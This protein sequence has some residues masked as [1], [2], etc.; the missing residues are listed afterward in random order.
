MRAILSI[1][2]LILLFF[3]SATTLLY[4]TFN[5]NID[6]YFSPKDPIYILDREIRSYFPED[7]V[8]IVLLENPNLFSDDFLGRLHKTVKKLQKVQDMNRVLTLT[9]V[10]HIQGTQD[11]F[12]ISPLFDP[13]E[14]FK[15]NIEERK[16]KI[17]QD[18][19][20]TGS[21][22][23]KDGNA[24]AVVLRPEKDSTT[25]AK[26]KLRHRSLQIFK[27]EQLGSSITA[28]SGTS[29][30]TYMQFESMLDSCKKFIPLSV[31]ISMGLICW[32]FPNRLAILLAFITILISIQ[33]P[34]ALL[35]LMGK[36][37][38]MIHTMALPLMSAL[39]LAALIHYFNRMK[40]YSNLG[41]PANV[42]AYD[43]IRE[44]RK[45]AAFATITTIVG[46]GSFSFTPIPAIQ[47][48]G[49]IT[50]FGELMLFI[51]VISILPP[52]FARYDQNQP[53]AKGYSINP[54][55]DKIT[56][57]CAKISIRHTAIVLWVTATIILISIPLALHV[58]IE[59]DVFRFY[60][61][62]HPV[63]INTH[64]VEDKLS[65]I[66]TL[67]VLL[68]SDTLDAFKKPENLHYL[69]TQQQWLETLPEV[70]RTTSM[71]D[72]IEDMQWAFNG[73]KQ[74]SR[75]IPD[76]PELIAQYLFIY[77]G[78]DLYEFV[79]H[80]FNKARIVVNLKVHE[81]GKIMHV[82][83]KIET[84]VKEIPKPD[85]TVQIAGFGALYAS[86]S[87][88]VVKTQIYSFIPSLLMIFVLLLIVFRS[89]SAAIICMLPNAAPMLIIFML[90]TVMG[91][92]LDVGTAMVASVGIG[93]AV[94]DTIH[95][96][97][98]YAQ[99]RQKGHRT[100]YALMRAYQ[101]AG[102]SALDTTLILMCQFLVIGLSDFI[103]TQSFGILSAIGVLTAVMFDLFVLPACIMAVSRPGLKP[104]KI[105]IRV[106]TFL[107]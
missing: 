49:I 103:P 24:I 47:T 15:L 68:K 16:K 33:M 8:F 19:M 54:F 57:V 48:F 1:S 90:M 13:A 74:E 20:A 80:D 107:H 102:R 52:L 10:D 9:T 69:R 51:I 89:F 105:A 83:N 28:I 32:M 17:L 71:A 101:H 72:I 40:F 96:Y 26:V 50:A 34:V 5:H 78:Q 92:W 43:A 41:S 97:H 14:D 61:E 91:Y 18:R 86:L 87:D 35:N 3:G 23:S 7:D 31:I 73:E 36:D 22:I 79:N 25:Q 30:I 53:W 62:D 84:H 37:F 42:R 46:L 88:L 67:T 106:R 65:G 11:G 66:N 58:K 70:D 81:A 95:L 38:T 64:R 21:I 44:I 99:K 63:N 45:P 55:L 6:I 93:I 100:V 2:V 60:K 59:T 76:D 104:L 77:D 85:L 56:R 4:T 98:A 27:D 94:D 12:K 82:I 39:S 29:E 75:T